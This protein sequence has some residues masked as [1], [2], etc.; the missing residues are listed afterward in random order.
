MTFI[1]IQG[2]AVLCGLVSIVLLH[3][4]NRVYNLRTDLID[5]VFSYP[6]YQWRVLI[7][8]SVSY[9]RMVYSFWKSI[10]VESFYK[11]ISFIQAPTKPVLSWM[12]PNRDT[13]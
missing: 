10:K 1:I 3:R 8:K 12:Q 6:D 7:M 13:A 9:N 4:N 11:D 5:K 2:L